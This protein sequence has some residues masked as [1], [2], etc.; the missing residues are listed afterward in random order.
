MRIRN[1]HN[2]LVDLLITAFTTAK[3]AGP[4]D[5]RSQQASMKVIPMSLTQHMLSGNFSQ[6]RMTDIHNEHTALVPTAFLPQT[7]AARLKRATDD[8]KRRTNE[9]IADIAA[10]QKERLKTSL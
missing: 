5:M 2:Q 10:D 8:K 3:S 4:L 6:I 1:S 7:N 9:D